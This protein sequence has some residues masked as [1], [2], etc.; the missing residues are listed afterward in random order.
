MILVDSNIIMYAAGAEHPCKAP[1]V[2]FLKNVAEAKVEATIDAEVLQEILHRFRAL[3]R[4]GDGRRVYDLARRIF[5]VVLP[6]TSAVLDRARILLDEDDRLM[7]RDALH[8]AVV[9]IN[10][11]AAI[12]S[13]DRDFDRISTI[14]RLEPSSF[15]RLMDDMSSKNRSS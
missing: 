13:Y 12:C 6:V 11:L 15:N 1:S 7:A 10:S 8:A 5:P 2:A 14:V 3:N 4:W 9:E